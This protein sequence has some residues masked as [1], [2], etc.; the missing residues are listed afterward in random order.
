MSLDP[1]KYDKISAGAEAIDNFRNL[2]LTSTKKGAW[3]KFRVIWEECIRDLKEIGNPLGTYDESLKESLL[4]KLP[5]EK[6]NWGMLLLLASKIQ[7]DLP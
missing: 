3:L 6:Y 5:F 4:T 1:L 7:M 2:K